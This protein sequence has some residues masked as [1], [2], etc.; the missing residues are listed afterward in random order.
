MLGKEG[1][2]V[3]LRAR[4]N[5]Q[6]DAPATMQPA[7]AN[8]MCAACGTYPIVTLLQ[9]GRMACTTASSL[10]VL[11]CLAAAM[12][13]HTPTRCDGCHSQQTLQRQMLRGQTQGAPRCE[14]TLCCMA[15]FGAGAWTW[16]LVRGR[17]CWCCCCRCAN[18]AC[19]GGCC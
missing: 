3:G 6:C 10:R 17:V 16:G 2:D 7:K 18:L 19:A 13:I 14:L 12:A 15:M 8:S 5:V 1:G 9:G 4:V 11:Q